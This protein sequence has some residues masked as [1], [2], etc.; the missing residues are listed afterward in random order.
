MEVY[1]SFSF[2]SIPFQNVEEGLQSIQSAGNDVCPAKRIGFAVANPR[3]AGGVLG[4]MA[5]RRAHKSAF[6][7]VWTSV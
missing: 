3:S 4:M 6:S 5:E 1:P 7:R 2:L